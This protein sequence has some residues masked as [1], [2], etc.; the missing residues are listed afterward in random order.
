MKRI[1]TITLVLI[2]GCLAAAPALVTMAQTDPP[3]AD[4]ARPLPQKTLSPMMQEIHAALAQND[5]VVETLQQNLRTA[6]DEQQALAMLRAIAQQKK[7]T[8]VSILRIQERYAQQ[9]GNQE[10]VAKLNQAI[11][12]ILNPTPVAPS[13]EAKAELEARRAQAQSGGSHHE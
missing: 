11:E 6:P 7:D 3:P 2:L 10:A 5:A 9:A 13:P 8:E 1:Q 12:Q 4:Q